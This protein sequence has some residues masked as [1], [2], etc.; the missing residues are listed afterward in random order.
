MALTPGRAI[1]METHATLAPPFRSNNGHGEIEADGVRH[2]IKGGDGRIS[3]EA[4][5]NLIN[6]GDKPLRLNTVYGPPNHLDKL[7]QRS[8][9]DAENARNVLGGIAS[10]GGIRAF[11]PNPRFNRCGAPLPSAR[12]Q[13]AFPK[14]RIGMRPKLWSARPVNPFC[15]HIPTGTQLLVQSRHLVD[16]LKDESFRL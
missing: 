7:V 15:P 10:D 1:N 6:T 4:K 13:P 3:A 12:N 16:R 5:H 11:P 8:K 14:R 2:T 9:T